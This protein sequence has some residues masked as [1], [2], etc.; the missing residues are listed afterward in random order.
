MPCVQLDE[1]KLL[2]DLSSLADKNRFLS[3]VREQEIEKKV[4]ETCSW[5]CLLKG[6]HFAERDN[7]I[8]PYSDHLSIYERLDG[9]R[10]LVSQPY[11][12]T[13]TIALSTELTNWLRE[14]G[15][16]LT[17]L[18]ANQ[19]WHMPGSTIL[20]QVEIDDI[21]TYVNYFYNK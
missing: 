1:I 14:R 5:T 17:L 3:W 4:S 12:D 6:R 13:K 10:V 19:S 8:M 16:I 20:F 11:Q 21:N 9:S 2:D 18:T 7:D 15:L